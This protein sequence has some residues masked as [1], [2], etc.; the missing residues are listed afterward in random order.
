MNQPKG[1]HIYMNCNIKNIFA[2]R[3]EP[4]DFISETCVASSSST[5]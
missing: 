4:Q 1:Q 3:S 2:A 5:R